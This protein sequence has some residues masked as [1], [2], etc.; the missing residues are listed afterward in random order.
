MYNPYAKEVK[1]LF[2]TQVLVCLGVF[3]SGKIGGAFLCLGLGFSLPIIV[4]A[5]ICLCHSRYSE[6]HKGKTSGVVGILIELPI[7]A[8]GIWG[9]Q[10]T[11]PAYIPAVI[12][13]ISPSVFVFGV[14]CAIRKRKLQSKQEGSRGAPPVCEEVE[15]LNVKTG[16]KN[17]ISVIAITVGVALMAGSI[18]LYLVGSHKGEVDSTIVVEETNETKDQII[19][20]EDVPYS[21]TDRIGFTNKYGTKTTVCAHPGCTDYIAL[22]GDTNCCI[23]HSSKC[24]DC[25]CY[26]DEGGFLCVSC[27]ATAA[28]QAQNNNTHYCEECGSKAVYS[29]I[30]I[31][32]TKEYYCY[33]HYKELQ[34]LMEW[35]TNN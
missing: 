19:Y 13:M 4:I 10:G 17:R 26:I 6:W 28:K 1:L 9:L 12:G 29:I 22:S 35:L 25:G 33:T 24:Y 14:T 30:G 7:L 16:H 2:L 3:I 23:A 27:I 32:G 34:D 31:T 20:A 8:A 11:E 15:R 5:I 18:V 21:S